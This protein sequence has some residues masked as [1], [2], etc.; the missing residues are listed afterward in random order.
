MSKP[1]SVQSLFILLFLLL[2]AEG[3]FAQLSVS[4]LFSDNMVLQQNAEVSIWGWS[5][6][7]DTI[8]ITGSWNNETIKTIAGADNKMG[9]QNSDST[10]ENRRQLL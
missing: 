6:P 5:N 1:T 8:S 7:G 9:G 2:L 4:G 3:V 10:S